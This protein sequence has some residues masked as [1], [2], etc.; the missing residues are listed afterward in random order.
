M[1]LGTH[2]LQLIICLL[3]FISCL[4]FGTSV[5]AVGV[6]VKPKEIDLS[7]KIGEETVA[8]FL[9]MNVSDQ[10][11]IYQVYPDAMNEEIK[12]GPTDFRLEPGASQIVTG[13]VTIKSPGRF[14]TNISIVARPL[15]AAGLVAASGVKLPITIVVSGFPL[16]WSIILIGVV[17]L[18]LIFT[19]LLK[20]RKKKLKIN[21]I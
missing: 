21:E 9:V 20:Q 7:V 1:K 14:N 10:P 6:G 18:V 4:F 16:L 3:I 11:A 2:N 19:L 8:E 12:V 13:K 5:Q 17:C 15:N